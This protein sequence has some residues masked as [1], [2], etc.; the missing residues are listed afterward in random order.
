MNR[1]FRPAWTAGRQSLRFNSRT[2]TRRLESTQPTPPTTKE[3]ARVARIESRLPKFL[4][5]FV[6]PLRNA[7]F[8]H[9]SAFLILHEITAV[10]P[11]LGLAAVFHYT[12]WLPPFI[13]EGK[14]FS[15]GVE[16]FGN[17][18]RKKG[19]LSGETRSGKWFGKGEKGT[20]LVAELATAYAI[21]KLLIPLRLIVSVWATPWFAT[22]TMLPVM[23]YVSK[24][25]RR[26]KAVT[27]SPG[28]AAGTGATGAGVVP[29]K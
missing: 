4:R 1:L 8:S 6:Q 28:A 19:W 18:M 23:N 15:D 25:L 14:W 11:L 17:Y 3:S 22:W 21:T 13:S 5:R 27:A 2:L 24:L 9:I 20:R 7:P 12:D 29:K 26:K 10:V 16:K